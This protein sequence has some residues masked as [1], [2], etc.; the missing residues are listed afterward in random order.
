MPARGAILPLPAPGSRAAGPH[1][2]CG[3]VLRLQL[4]QPIP[5]H[6]QVVLG[7]V[8][9]HQQQQLRLVNVAAGGCRAV[10]GAA[11]WV[12]ADEGDIW[13]SLLGAG[14]VPLQVQGR[15]MQTPPLQ[16]LLPDRESRSKAGHPPMRE[17]PRRMPWKA[18]S[19]LFSPK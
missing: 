17:M 7:A 2:R 6:L 13:G 15:L 3:A 4:L 9:A 10:M 8:A 1:R 12:W 16:G 14:R 18:A 5:E 19:A 11:S